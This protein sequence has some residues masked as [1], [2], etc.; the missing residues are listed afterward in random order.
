MYPTAI[1]N[2]IVWAIQ[3][4]SSFGAP[5]QAW[6]ESAASI[7]IG[8]LWQGAIVACG[9]ALYLRFASSVPARLRYSICTAGFAAIFC[10][11]FL[12]ALI[13]ILSSNGF[14]HPA[15]HPF[16]LTA[17]SGVSSSSSSSAWFSLDT[18]WSLGLASLWLAASL[19]RAT[20][21]T[22]H[23]A[24]M[25]RLWRSA[26]PVVTTDLDSLLQKTAARSA[27]SDA[28]R[29]AAPSLRRSLAKG[30]DAMSL[31]LG[32]IN[33]AFRAP[34]ELCVTNDLDRPC[35]IGF[36]RP[37]ILI[38]AWLFN[39][40]TPAE[41]EQVVLHESE[42][43]RRMDD[44]TNLL[45]KVCLVVFPL[46]PALWWLERRLCVEREMA[47]DDAV[48][49]RTQAPRAYAACLAGLAERGLERR[50]A[51]LARVSLSLG[52]WQHRP[53]LAT[54]VHRLLRRPAAMN[55]ATSAV[56]VAVI[57]CGLVAG[58]FTLAHSPRLVAFVSPVNQSSG[59]LSLSA[60]N[61]QASIQGDARTDFVPSPTAFAGSSAR[62]Y[63]AVKTFAIL[64]ATRTNSTLRNS[65]A[66]PASISPNQDDQAQHNGDLNHPNRS[67]AA[68]IPTAIAAGM[69]TQQAQLAGSQQASQA[70]APHSI[71]TNANQ[72]GPT[73]PSSA[74]TGWIVLT[75]YEEVQ[76]ASSDEASHVD[77]VAPQPKAAS[78]DTDP[79][80]STGVTVRRLVFRL[81][82][83]TSNVQPATNGQPASNN[84][85]APN[86]QPASNSLQPIM[87]PYRDGWFVIQL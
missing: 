68:I 65:N 47:C 28:A 75:T 49:H 51:A 59:T 63:R 85:S 22:A 45:Q 52:A 84:P 69:K 73:Q 46:N 56:S 81:I 17:E 8:S 2:L 66:T 78:V 79:K 48:V 36:F 32:R 61:T 34:A 27:Q 83:P 3:G 11:P 42:H 25:R 14:N 38:P 50:Q 58:T 18:R 21:L 26:S 87:I 20:G 55:P 86:V 4:A 1:L 9:L 30:W 62:P 35:V 71:Q 41:L 72:P 31:S 44:W 54:R 23:A 37:R 29:R 15:S 60:R 24:R 7:L 74:Q 67:L 76:T 77:A 19:V 53:E 82:Q 80:P 39:R 40:L 5:A 10:L 70:T 16:G 12:P 57:G 43:L 13:H 33:V 64:P 6:S